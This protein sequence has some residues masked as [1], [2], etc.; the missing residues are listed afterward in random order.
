MGN[1]ALPHGPS[2][3][4]HPRLYLP[5]RSPRCG[6]SSAI[7][8]VADGLPASSV[9]PPLTLSVSADAFPAR[10]GMFPRN[11]FFIKL[12]TSNSLRRV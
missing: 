10:V 3:R 6:K 7:E 8:S 1:G 2:Y 12:H 9:P 11:L 5:G 4:A